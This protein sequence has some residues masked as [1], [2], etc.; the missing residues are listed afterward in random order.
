MAYMCNRFMH[1]W[2]NRP[3]EGKRGG[4]GWA[5]DTCLLQCPRAGS[6]G[7][8]CTDFSQYVM[9][10]NLARLCPGAA[11]ARGIEVYAET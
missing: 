1:L 7:N 3:G 11:A 10:S 6:C 8:A 9:M 5:A 4:G 2:Y